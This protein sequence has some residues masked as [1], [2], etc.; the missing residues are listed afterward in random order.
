[1]IGSSTA[2]GAS[3]AEERTFAALLPPLLSRDTGRQI[4]VYNAAVEY[5]RPAALVLQLDRL[6]A[7]EPADE[8]L[9]IL[10]PTDVRDA[11]AVTP[12][13]GQLRRNGLIAAIRHQAAKVAETRSVH[14]LRE[15]LHYLF[16]RSRAATVILNYWYMNMSPDRYVDSYL[17][18]DDSEIGFLKVQ[19]SAQWQD[20]L[21]NFEGYADRIVDKVNAAGVPLTAALIPDRAQAVIIARN[22]WKAGFDP[23]ALNNQLREIIETHG[24]TSLDVLHHYRNAPGATED[25]F[26]VDGHP[27]AEG[28]ALLA[29]FADELT[30]A[31]VPPTMPG[32][33]SKQRK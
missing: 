30:S 29:R 1:M 11:S 23:Y 32:N 12:D 2:L 9:W 15:S 28:H 24:G 3:V 14:P 13:Q 33:R 20:R 18:G 6:L 22:R 5:Q 27:N 25:Y 8:I 21:R 17:D 31:S 10:T 7:E 16:N 26:P 4:E 19:P